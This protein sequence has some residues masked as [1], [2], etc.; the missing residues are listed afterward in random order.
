METLDFELEL[1]IACVYSPKWRKDIINNKSIDH[2]VFDNQTYK[3]L[4][5]HVFKNVGEDTI[6]LD[7]ITGIA[8]KI[9][10]YQ[11]DDISTEI[12]I[13]CGKIFKKIRN[14]E[15]NNLPVV[16]PN[17]SMNFVK[18]LSQKKDIKESLTSILSAL[19]GK[20]SED[21][22][23]EL[24]FNE[25]EKLKKHRS[26]D[27][28]YIISNPLDNI[29]KRIEGR[30][31]TYNNGNTILF[32]ASPLHYFF[33]L[34]IGAAESVGICADTNVGKSILAENLIELIIDKPNSR[35]LLYIYTENEQIQSEARLDAMVG[36]V[37]YN[38]AYSGSLDEQEIAKL[39]A[40]YSE[41]S[42]TGG[43]LFFAKVI[44]NKFTILT[45]TDIVAE[46]E[47]EHNLKIHVI[48]CDS[49]EHQS[50]TFKFK[51]H[52]MNK[53]AVYL[54]WKTYY[55]MKRISLITTIQ[56]KVNQSEMF[57]KGKP[58]KED[59]MDM[60]EPPKPE[61]AAGSVEIPRM[62]DYMLVI[63][64]REGLDRLYKRNKLWLIKARNSAIPDAPLYLY[65]DSDNLR[66][67]FS[68]WEPNVVKSKE[69][70]SEDQKSGII[71]N[72]SGKTVMT[73]TRKSKPP[74]DSDEVNE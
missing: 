21:E 38:K 20:K 71:K 55:S 8:S 43:K 56:R 5:E 42:N 25:S 45:V 49:P 31:E 3:F 41:L 12:E 47:V 61:E 39:K 60:P 11:G 72:E 36:K 34:G 68:R 1:M 54:E 51:E 50:P 44:P 73:V 70:T 40:R 30:K 52:W 29:E 6:T 9:P 27:S 33:P 59:D 23:L 4:W 57:K 63:N 22:V 48:I 28:D 13:D 62:L 53:A 35:N 16:Y 14:R 18:R 32:N 7:I 69:Q 66:A 46:L 10:K 67:S 2:N 58:P 19:E 24:F 65:V 15:K 64:R 26:A 37:S 17:M 74:I